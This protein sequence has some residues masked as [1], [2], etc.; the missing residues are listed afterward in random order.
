MEFEYFSNNRQRM[1]YDYSR[2]LGLCVGSGVVESRLQGGGHH[3]APKKTGHVL[4]PEGSRHDR[5]LLQPL[6]NTFDDF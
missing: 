1:R 6:S 4:E 3:P 2:S 5:P